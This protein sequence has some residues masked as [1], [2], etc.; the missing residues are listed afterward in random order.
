M[1]IASGSPYYH[2]AYDTTTLA[3]VR[4][5]GEGIG[6]YPNSATV[7]PDGVFLA[8]G[9]HASHVLSVHRV[10]DGATV[11]VAD[12]TSGDL[13]AGSLAFAGADVFGLLYDWYNQRVYLWRVPGATLASSAISLTA[14]ASATALEPLTIDGRLTLSDNS[15]PGAQQLAV[16]RTLPDGTSAE[17]PAVTTAADG[18]FSVTDSP[19]VAGS[20]RYT[21]A[22]DG[23]DTYSG[24]TETVTV[25]VGKRSALLT[26]TG[27]AT[28]EAGKRI[29]LSG[30]LTLDGAAPSPAATLEVYRSTYNNRRSTTDRLADVTTDSHGAFRIADTP[31]RGVGAS[32]TRSAGAGTTPTP[33]RRPAT[34]SR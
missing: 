4:R 5:Y 7:I 9:R 27:P 25:E 14:D 1:I 34:R 8:A 6:Y 2:P 10:A 29:R 30:T 3:E 18:T 11:S 31:Q 13:V 15:A 19:P 24:S 26:L 28:G 20:V 21:V 12:P 22:W 17:L 16:T 23:N 33:R 32:S